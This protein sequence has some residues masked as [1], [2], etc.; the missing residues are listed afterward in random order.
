MG[1]RASIARSNRAL[2]TNSVDIGPVAQL[3]RVLI[4]MEVGNESS[5]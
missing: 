1:D 5:M 3:V 2:P 4:I